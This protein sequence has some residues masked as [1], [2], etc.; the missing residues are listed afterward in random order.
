MSNALWCD[1]GDHAFSEKDP[2]KRH[3]TETREVDGK[4]VTEVIDWCGEH[5]KSFLNAT[6][7]STKAIQDK[8]G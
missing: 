8:V 5:A 1:A 4:P 3:F 6:N 7:P 2:D